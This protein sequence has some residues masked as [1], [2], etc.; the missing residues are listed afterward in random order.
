MRV[1]I[2]GSSM[3]EDGRTGGRADGR[4]A[5]DGRTEEREGGR[6]GTPEARGGDGPP[7]RKWPRAWHAAWPGARTGAWPGART[8]A[9]PGER[10]G[11]W[12]GGWNR[13][14]GY[15]LFR[16]AAVVAALAGPSVVTSFHLP[17]L[18]AQSLARRLDRQL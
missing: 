10:N 3:T 5:E 8:G 15:A 16:R 4:T 6:T 2:H 9:Q 12:A 17:V 18:S 11:A 14:V 7:I 13:R 1:W